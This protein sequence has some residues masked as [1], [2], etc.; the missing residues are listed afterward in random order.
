MI[1]QSTAES[2]MPIRVGALV[3]QGGMVC[4]GCGGDCETKGP[5][6]Q[7]RLRFTMLAW[8]PVM[9]EE[10]AKVHDSPWYGLASDP[11]KEVSEVQANP[12]MN[13]INQ[14]V[15]YLSWS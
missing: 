7:P 11:P 6:A 5:H 10:H 13:E 12:A 15:R 1:S 8:V 2:M 4:V 3:T 9:T 14:Y